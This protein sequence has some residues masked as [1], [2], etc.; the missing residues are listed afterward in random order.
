MSEIALGLLVIGVL[1]VS[2]P[3]RLQLIVDRVQELIAWLA[4]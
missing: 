4:E 3:D 2:D 1:V